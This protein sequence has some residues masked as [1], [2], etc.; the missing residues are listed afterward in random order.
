SRKPGATPALQRWKT[1][2]AFRRA[3]RE[4]LPGGVAGA[5][6]AARGA[7]RASYS[8]RRRRSRTESGDGAA[9]EA[10]FGIRAPARWAGAAGL[11]A[12]ERAGKVRG[13]FSKARAFGSGAA[14]VAAGVGFRD[15]KR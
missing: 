12:R 4:R 5:H 14:I 2:A 1:R 8:L 11:P 3:R 10:A 9:L 13:D 6:S 7:A 15:G